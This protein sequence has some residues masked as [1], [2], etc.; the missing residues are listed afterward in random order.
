MGLGA[1][2][3][4]DHLE[5]AGGT[6]RARVRVSVKIPLVDFHCEE[7]ERRKR[8][9]LSEQFLLQ[10]SVCV[11]VYVGANKSPG[12]SFCCPAWPAVCARSVRERVHAHTP[13]GNT[14]SSLAGPGDTAVLH[15]PI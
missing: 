10:C 13:V 2:N 3:Y 8:T 6:Q 4:I 11:C 12:L 15:L 14:H 5:L 9:G 7:S 1:R